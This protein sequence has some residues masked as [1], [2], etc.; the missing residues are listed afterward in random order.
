MNKGLIL[1]LVV[2]MAL[3]P[4]TTLFASGRQ[5]AGAQVQ[6]HAFVFKNTG[7]PYCEKHMEGFAER[8]RELGF[9]PILR[10][11]EIGRAHD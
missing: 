3:A 4:I 11:P 6:R 1:V 10:A 7:N 8:I 5:E 2:V 9:E